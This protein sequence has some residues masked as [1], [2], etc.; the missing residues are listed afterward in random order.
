MKHYS[1]K[2]NVFLYICLALFAYGCSVEND[3]VKEQNQGKIK[4]K[5][6]TLEELLQVP[7]FNEAYQKVVKKKTQIVN[8]AMAR[9]ALEDIYNLTIV[10]QLPIKIIEKDDRTTY[11]MKIIKDSVVENLDE[12]KLENLVIDIRNDGRIAA[13][14]FK[15]L[16]SGEK[17]ESLD[18]SFKIG[19][20]ISVVIE[21]LEIEGQE[22]MTTDCIIFQVLLCYYG[23]EIHIAGA[24]CGLTFW[25]DPIYIGDGCP[26]QES[27]DAG[28][29]DTSSGDTSSGDT[30]SGDTSSGTT[31]SGSTSTGGSGTS[32]TGEIA[33]FIN[34]YL[35]SIEVNGTSNPVNNNVDTSIHGTGGESL[36]YIYVAPNDCTG[37]NDNCIEDD[38]DDCNTS[39]EKLALM[40]PNAPIS[41]LEL[42]AQV[43]N[44]KGKD[45]GIDTKEK[46][47]H[48]LSQA[49]HES[50][51]FSSINVTEDLYYTTASR[52]AEIWPTRFSLT[53]INK[54]DPTDYINNSSLLG[55]AVY[56]D[57][58]GN[59]S[60][61][62]GDGYK[63]RGRGIVQLTGRTGYTDFETF[64]NQTF[65]PSI[66]I[67]SNPNLVASDNNLS[68]LSALWFYKV[69]VLDKITVNENTTVKAV[70]YKINGGYNGLPDRITKFTNAVLNIDCLD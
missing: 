65:S 15:F 19:G 44:E 32:S 53:D 12:K 31:S 9:T 7:I 33:T 50:G 18:N 66:Q 35:L 34:L 46:L 4:L 27:D 42:L 58:M 5:T 21:P 6:K 60:I 48:F 23:G 57:R 13:T 62:S 1:K 55:N 45:F 38:E 26:D 68:I 20:G 25:S 14:I 59:G 16:Y 3:L 47:Q 43:I 39:K 22:R 36:N 56:H 2:L 17:T 63:Y 28:S 54:L 37:V 70:T 29:G 51:N 10:S 40:F 11:T 24:N 64:Y 69:K 49:G 30:S 61:S 41:V 67:V 52:I 8:S